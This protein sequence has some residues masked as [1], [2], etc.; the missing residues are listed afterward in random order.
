MAQRPLWFRVERQD[1]V[2]HGIAL[3]PKTRK[4]PQ[5]YPQV[6]IYVMLQMQMAVPQMP[7]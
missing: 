2:I 1:I 5:V 3:P 6:R 4:L 7:P